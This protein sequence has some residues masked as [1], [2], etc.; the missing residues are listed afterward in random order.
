VGEASPGGDGQRVVVEVK[1][2]ALTGRFSDE[3]V[4][5]TTSTSQPVL[6]VKVLGTIDP[7]PRG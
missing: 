3:V 1:G 5:R 2:T 4:L 7:D 6:T